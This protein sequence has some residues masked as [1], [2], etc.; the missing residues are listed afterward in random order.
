MLGSRLYYDKVTGA[1]HIGRGHRVMVR[2]ERT[3]DMQCLR[4]PAITAAA[5][6]TLMLG[7]T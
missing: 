7:S 1:L 5:K 3:I 4:F 2:A 6:R